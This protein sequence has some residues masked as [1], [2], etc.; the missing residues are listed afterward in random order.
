MKRPSTAA[1]TSAPGK[2]KHDNNGARQEILKVNA[3][4]DGFPLE[5]EKL[6][7]PVTESGD[8]KTCKNVLWS[9]K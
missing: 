8:L 6:M 2:R 4:V 5:L 7:Q 1:K 3:S 9:F